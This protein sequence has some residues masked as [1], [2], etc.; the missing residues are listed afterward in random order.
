MLT[1]VLVIIIIILLVWIFLGTK[2]THILKLARKNKKLREEI[3][4]LRGIN[5]TLR[6]GI[7]STREEIS[8]QVEDACEIAENLQRLKEALLG[9]KSAK[10]ALRKDFNEEP[11][12]ELVRHILEAKPQIRS[13]LKRRLSSGVLAGDLGIDVLR[14]L[15]E[16]KSIADVAADA[17]VPIHAVRSRITLLQT[18]GYIDNRLGL[19]ELGRKAIGV[20]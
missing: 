11:G 9:N 17:G 16:G 2:T 4:E 7:G 12:P 14:G 10:E 1:I 8:G 6:S 18:T 20:S 19:T 5:R 3:E 13:R 15:N